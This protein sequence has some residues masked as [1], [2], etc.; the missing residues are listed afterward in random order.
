MRV[1]GA[2]MH[3]GAAQGSPAHAGM[4]PTGRSAGGSQFL[5]DIHR[6]LLNAT[7][8]SQAIGQLA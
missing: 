5:F 3:L 8:S 4:E 6:R 1:R 2:G 7:R